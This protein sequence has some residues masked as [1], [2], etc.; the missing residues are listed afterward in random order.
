MQGSI[1]P[2]AVAHG[3]GRVVASNEHLASLNSNNQVTLRYVDSL[4]NQLNIIH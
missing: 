1:L 4:G 3:E 2:I